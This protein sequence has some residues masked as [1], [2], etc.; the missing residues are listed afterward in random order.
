VTCAVALKQKRCI[1]LK[2]RGVE[3]EV[4]LRKF[5]VEISGETSTSTLDRGRE[6]A[7][8]ADHRK[9]EIFPTG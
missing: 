6:L 1:H 2:P 7:A 9:A 8:E 5:V 3:N 4:L